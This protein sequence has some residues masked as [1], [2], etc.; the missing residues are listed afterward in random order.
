MAT[1]DY[2]GENSRIL[3]EW[4]ERI[5]KRTQGIGGVNMSRDGIMC[6]GDMIDDGANWIRK[7]SYEGTPRQGEIENEKWGEAP[8]RILIMVKDQNAGGGET[9]DSSETT[10]RK[11]TADKDD[12]IL[13]RHPFNRRLS[14]VT[15]GLLNTTNEHMVELKDIEEDD[16]K[17]LDFLDNNLFAL[18]NCKKEAG[19]PRCDNNILLDAMEK[20]GD[21]LLKQIQNIDPDIF[22]CCGSTH[23]GHVQDHAYLALGF[24]ETHGYS[25]KFMGRKD[26]MYDIYYDSE[27]NK[28][29]IDS[30]HPTYPRGRS[31]DLEFYKEAV[32]TYYQFLQ[33][34][35][36]FLKSHRNK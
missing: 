9:W 17:V 4:E 12:C 26:S 8:I 6:K 1:K 18:I 10:F 19:G 34:H 16:K 21:L 15:Y 27:R 23:N 31:H 2:V 35:P 3:D 14:W 22:V 30:F 20:D 36:D 28:L 24:L 33:E 11:H 32:E 7:I 25:F 13:S 29:A 5:N